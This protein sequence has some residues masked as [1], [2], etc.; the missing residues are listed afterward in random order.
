MR[1]PS[2]MTRHVLVACRHNAARSVL[3]EAGGR[4]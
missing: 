4:P 3:A 2:D 1:D